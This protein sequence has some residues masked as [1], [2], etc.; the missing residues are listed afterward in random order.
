M[1]RDLESLTKEN[2]SKSQAIDIP[3]VSLPKGGGAVRGIDEKFKV[4]PSNGSTALQ[5]PL[6]ITAGRNGFNPN[7]SVTYNSGSG[8]GPFGLGFELTLGGIQRRTDK[9]IPQYRDSDSFL[10]SGLEELVPFL[11]DRDEPSEM[12]ADGFAVKRYRPRIEGDFSRVEL[13]SHPERG[14]YWKVTSAANSVTY[15]GLSSESRVQDPNDPGRVFRW[16]PELSLDKKGNCIVYEY[17]KENLEGVPNDPHELNRFGG[18]AFFTNT[19]L[20]RVK[21]GNKVPYYPN[22]NYHPT[23]PIDEFFYELVF[24]YGEHGH[25]PTEENAWK[26]RHDAFSNYRAGFEIR[27]YRLCRQVMMFHH[28][29]GEIKR[30][31]EAFGSNYL[32]KSLRFSYENSSI[33]DSG[34]SEVTYLSSVRQN[35]H[36]R[37]SDG[38]YTTQSLPPLK[39]EYQRLNWDVQPM[40][41]EQENIVHAPVGITN[42]YFWVDLWNEGTNGILAEFEGSWHY[43]SNLGDPDQSGEVKFSNAV[44]VPSIPI[45]GGIGIGNLAIQD[46]SG[47]GEKSIVVNTPNVSGY[48]KINQDQTIEPF[49]AIPSDIKIDFEDPNIRRIDLSGNG[50]ADILISED[51]AFTCFASKGEEGFSDYTRTSKSFDEEAGPTIVFADPKQTIFLA[52]MSGDGLT[53]IVRVRRNEICYWPNVGYGKF[54]AKVHMSNAPILDH[55]SEFNPQFIHLADVSGT[56]TTDI[57]YITDN[58]VEVFLN[59]SGNR[60]SEAHEIST[61]FS[62]NNATNVAVIDLMAKGTSCIVWS[63]DLP[64]DSKAPLKYIDL[65]GGKK[66]HLLKG[67]SNGTGLRVSL[68]YKSSSEFYLED[69]RNG[70][71]WITK[72]PFHIQLLTKQTIEDRIARTSFSSSYTYH[73]GHYDPIEKEFRGFGRVDQTDSEEYEEWVKNHSSSLLEKA[74]VHYQAPTMVRT[75]FHTGSTTSNGLLNQYESEYWHNQYAQLFPEEPLIEELSLPDGKLPA[76]V[77]AEEWEQAHRACKG[78]M[79]RQEIFSLDGKDEDIESL[80]KQARPYAVTMQNCQLNLIQGQHIDFPAVFLPLPL[81]SISIQYERNEKDPRIAHTLN[82]EYDAF[83]NPLQSVSVV[84]PRSEQH[85]DESLVQWHNNNVHLEQKEAEAYQSTLEF[86]RSQQAGTSKIIATQSN[87]TLPIDTESDYLL[88]TLC[89]VKEY[90]ATGFPKNQPLYA[91]SDFNELLTKEKIPYHQESDPSR[92]QIR[93]VEHS[94]STFY[95]E[96]IKGELPLGSIASHGIPFQSYQLAYTPELID[97]IYGGKIDPVTIE[98]LFEEGK[99]IKRE[100]NWWIRSGQINFYQ[101]DDEALDDV[102]DRFY[103]PLSFTDPFG[104]ETKVEYHPDFLFITKTMDEVN[105]STSIERFDFRTLSPTLVRDIND[106]LSEVLLDEL[107]MVKASAILGKDLDSD[108]VPEL[109]L[110]DTLEGIPEKINS[111]AAL[112]EVFFNAVSSDVLHQIARQLLKGASS[113]MVY[114]LNSYESS[115][116]PTVAASIVRERHHQEMPDSPLQISFE[117]SD[118]AGNVIMT[119]VQAEPGDAKKATFDGDGHVN[120]QNVNTALM[121]PPQLRWIGNGRTVLNNKGNPVKQY[122]PYFSVTHKFEDLPELVETG[123]TPILYYDGMGRNMKTVMP[124]KTFSKVEFDAWTQRSFDPNDTVL[125]SE[126]YSDRINFLSDAQL[127]V[128]GKDPDKEREAA[129]KAAE[130]ANTPEHLFLDSLG[131]PIVSAEHNRTE[132]Q[133]E[134][135]LTRIVLDVE[136]NT[137]EVIDARSNTVMSYKYDMLGHRVYQ[138]SMDA[139][140]RWMFNNA[141]GNPVKSWDQRHQTFSATYDK[142]QRPLEMKI[143]RQGVEESPLNHI[144]E[145]YIYG[146]DLPE[147]RLRNLRGI[148]AISYDTA[149]KVVIDKIDL[150]GNILE[151]SRQFTSDYKSEVNWQ[152]NNL[153]AKLEADVFRSS[154]SYDALNRPV[155]TTSADNSIATPLYNEAGLLRTVA[156]TQNGEEEV[157]VKNISY[158]EKGQRQSIVYGSDVKTSYRYDRETF[159]LIHMVSRKK[160]GSLLQDYHYTFDPTGN[161]TEIEDKSVPT[162][163]FD[164][165]R[166]EP[167]SKYTYDSLYR[168]IAADG[169][170]HRATVGFGPQDNWYHKDFKKTYSPGDDMAWR[171]Y[172]QHYK[173]DAVGNILQLKHI[174]VD[175][176]WTRDYQYEEANNRLKQT[177][178]GANRYVYHHHPAHGYITQLP[179]LPTMR[180][181]FKEELQA[182]AKQ[183]VLDGTGEIT[184]C[185]YD[186]EGQRARKVTELANGT[187]KDER[188]Y[189]GDVEIYY[190]HHGTHDGLERTTLHISDD[191]GRIAMIDTRNDVDDNTEERT[192]RYQMGNHLGSAS[193]E[194]NH[195]GDV[196]TYEEY[197]PYGTCAYRAQNTKIKVAAKRYGYTSMEL[198]ESGLAYHTARYYLPWL[199]RWL[200]SD[201]IGIEGGIN[202]FEYSRSSPT[203]YKDIKGQNPKSQSSN[204]IIEER[205]IFVSNKQ[206][207]YLFG[208]RPL[209]Q[210]EKLSRHRGEKHLESITNRS[211]TNFEK[212][213]FHKVNARNTNGTRTIT[214]LTTIV[215]ARYL[216]EAPYIEYDRPV[217]GYHVREINNGG[218]GV[219]GFEAIFDI[220]GNVLSYERVWSPN[221]GSV[222]PSIFSPIDILSIGKTFTSLVVKKLMSRSASK[223]LV[224][225]TDEVLE[226]SSKVLVRETSEKSGSSMKLLGTTRDRLLNRAQNDRLR[227]EI[228][229]LYRPKSMLGTGS[230]GEA[231]TLEKVTG[232]WISKSTHL[233]KVL[234][235]RKKLIDLVRS[236]TLSNSDKL[237]AREILLDLQKALTAP[238]RYSKDL[239]LKSSRQRG[240]PLPGGSR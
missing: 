64:A 161:I 93:L 172:Q 148:A 15:Y 127:I 81:E 65:M 157:F 168:L 152:G 35:G 63:S 188:Y 140:E 170:E 139:G 145:K 213:L 181:N 228:D 55:D 32:V 85:A 21:Y 91:P 80:K 71:D 143:V 119:K 6:P 219:I 163:F 154:A 171:A 130:H 160:D 200:S 158:D 38:T 214:P 106:N 49:Q 129:H 185:L 192:V 223:V 220:E 77:N 120:L 193:L 183:S 135:Y 235:R 22:H 102:K 111:E 48:Y 218:S 51:Q 109:E 50:V 128:D 62:N 90:E 33:N 159:R 16:L 205:Q 187:K 82:L 75:W 68:E 97:D 229:Q 78:M 237:I 212:E 206:G 227:N 116:A 134:F 122:E 136:S 84:Y 231:L 202:L 142:I 195:A 40:E 28:F 114:D 105:N 173:Y 7:L 70:H 94:Q 87:Y 3:S 25:T 207:I 146:E 191:T 208:R 99:F 203:R 150:K 233:A 79:I 216:N 224:S 133:D 138:K 125:E 12:N 92:T 19:Y 240:I 226:E 58:L 126:W 156:V 95:D 34:D 190:K 61:N 123:V 117:Y 44:E 198:D 178:V 110:C 238:G 176:N 132:G 108:K 42:N 151:S 24:D 1:N 57:L 14:S 69:K 186:G 184:Y 221:N 74:E 4:N 36:I 137:K 8:N 167:R 5:I 18:K 236:G 149:G 41:V 60:C 86:I 72:L 162:K 39:L 47:N 210:A 217:I 88:P 31:G 9:R 165:F 222:E 113:R 169:K 232:L 104:A 100:N 112:I 53:D 215:N 239:I 67:Y 66:P 153:D 103:V 147:S 29:P 59:I 27:T 23:P 45:F 182:T 209:D 196:I 10:I 234:Q 204:E 46:L 52:D 144:Y 30:D 189:L 124:D 174:A 76:N 179:H 13:I 43:S 164:N 211:L 166:V 194:T 155:T 121:T 26:S 197:H 56:G 17:K 230:T 101:N 131:R 20:K 201:P 2:P 107:G 54:G 180:W 115:N 11:D 141:M 37:K 177:E 225:K 118:G 98:D 96:A 175:G 89:E 83:G 199:G 73:H